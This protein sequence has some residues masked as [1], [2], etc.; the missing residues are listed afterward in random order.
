MTDET[1]FIN[2]E[3]QESESP[4]PQSSTYSITMSNPKRPPSTKTK[5]VQPNDHTYSSSSTKKYTFSSEDESSDS[6]KITNLLRR[7]R[8]K[9]GVKAPKRPPTTNL[10]RRKRAKLLL[11]RAKKRKMG[12]KYP[13]RLDRARI[14]VK[15]R[16]KISP[17]EKKLAKDRQYYV[18]NYDRIQQI[19]FTPPI[20]VV[21]G[22]KQSISKNTF[23]KSMHSILKRKNIGD[24]VLTEK[25]YKA[26]IIS[27]EDYLMNIM[28][29]AMQLP[30]YCDKK[31]L[32]S[33]ALDTEWN[34]RFRKLNDKLKIVS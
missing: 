13:T 10:L 21:R 31:T 11:E 3:P 32:T 33:H 27:I 28:I 12:I 7:E 14:A 23:D 1:I 17:K 5:K 29:N 26:L 22:H 16:R 4:D 8:A 25:A 6:K 34:M 15:E 30:L 24:I 2:L 19:N 20:E 18:D 9:L